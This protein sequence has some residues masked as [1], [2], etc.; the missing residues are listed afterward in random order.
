MIAFPKPSR[1]SCPE[2][3]EKVRN[4]RCTVCQ[5]WPSDAHHI[6]SRGA[7][8]H[9]TGDNLMPLCQKHHTE[10]HQIGVGKMIMKY[11]P[12]FKWLENYERADVIAKAQA[13][14]PFKDPFH[15]LKKT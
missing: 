8:G 10:W 11:P 2:L 4:M 9:D 5:T 7:G 6:T 13:E 1:K 14:S 3:I 15:V 12:I